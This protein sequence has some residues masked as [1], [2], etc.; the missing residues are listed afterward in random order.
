MTAAAA[1]DVAAARGHFAGLD[2][3][4]A[5]LRAMCT[6]AL[7]RADGEPAPSPYDMTASPRSSWSA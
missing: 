4:A 7:R 6:D 2:V 3:R 5:K 1:P